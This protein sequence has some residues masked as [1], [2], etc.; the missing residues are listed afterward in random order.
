MGSQR[1]G[2]NWATFT[3]TFFLI[4]Q[5]AGTEW[6]KRG[7]ILENNGYKDALE[8]VTI[9]I[10]FLCLCSC[11]HVIY[12]SWTAHCSS[13]H[14]LGKSYTLYPFLSSVKTHLFLPQIFSVFKFHWASL[15]L[16]FSTTLC[17]NCSWRNCTALEHLNI[18]TANWNVLQ[19]KILT[20]FPIAQKM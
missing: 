10:F 8:R 7:C 6:R 14:S 11:S 17:K 2:H 3:F 12:F 20:G 5:D 13:L 18:A 16:I 15:S 4:P 1:V 9:T 19:Y